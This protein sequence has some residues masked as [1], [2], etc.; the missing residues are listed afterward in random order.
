MSEQFGDP[1]LC[2]DILSLCRASQEHVEINSRKKET[3]VT[4]R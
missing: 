1:E 2:F 3:A 4:S